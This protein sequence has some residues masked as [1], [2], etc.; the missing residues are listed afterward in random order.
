M[1]MLNLCNYC[2]LHL[3]YG[4]NNENLFNFQ[5]FVQLVI[6]SFIFMTLMFELEVLL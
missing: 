4:T 1:R 3:A 2:S 5:E 6:I